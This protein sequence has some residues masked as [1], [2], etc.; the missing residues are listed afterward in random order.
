MPR[1]VLC[2]LLSV[3]RRGGLSRLLTLPRPRPGEVS[4]HGLAEGFGFERR[5]QV[6]C[7]GAVERGENRVPSA[8]GERRV[9]GRQDLVPFH[10]G[11]NFDANIGE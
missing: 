8:P 7:A 3:W 2:T 11:C 10:V 4:R 5:R 6:H 1:F 9:K